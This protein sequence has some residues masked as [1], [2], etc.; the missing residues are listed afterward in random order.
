MSP[1][2]VFVTAVSIAVGPIL[3]AVWLS[4][5][6]R[7]ETFRG[8]PSSVVA[9]AGA[10]T[11]CGLLI[12]IVLKEGASFDVAESPE[13]LFMYVMVGLAWVRVVQSLFPY[14]GLSPRDD[15]F[16]RRNSAAAFSLVGAMIGVT[17]CYAGG[18]VGDGPGWWVVAFSAGLA[19]AGWMISWAILG[20]LTPVNDAVAIDRDHAAG[21]R[22]GAY[23]VASGLILGR[24]V[25]GDWVSATGVLFDL[26][27]ALPA[28]VV[29]LLLAIIVERLAR[30]TAHRP[31]G[32]LFAFGFL[33]AALYLLV[34]VAALSW[35]GWP[36]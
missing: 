17:L 11:A 29:I 27:T 14:L 30:P 19:T 16:E 18:N 13:Y 20:Q 26:T 34:G 3:W 4:R 6:A 24:G 2:E 9:I 32:S 31:H 22:L 12:F 28:I 15:V 10:I 21:I 23:L 25:A 5:M 36:A 33:P 1:D 8:R 35:K 7:L